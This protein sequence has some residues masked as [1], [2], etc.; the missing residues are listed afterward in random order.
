MVT[1]AY[2]AT[3]TKI[4]ERFETVIRDPKAYGEA[5]SEGKASEATEKISTGWWITISDWPVSLGVG[6]ER[7]DFKIG[8]SISVKIE[9]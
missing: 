7:P 1:I 6:S 4:E 8:Q 2:A 5:K 3:I 9:G